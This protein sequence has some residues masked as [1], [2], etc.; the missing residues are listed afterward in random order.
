MEVG[1]YLEKWVKVDLSN[2]YYYEGLVIGIDNDSITLRDKFDKS[3]TILIK[4]ILFIREV[5]R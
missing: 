5:E 4:L 2:G 3:V 1:N